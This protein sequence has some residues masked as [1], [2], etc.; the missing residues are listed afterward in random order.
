MLKR[1]ILSFIFFSKSLNYLGLSFKLTYLNFFSL[2]TYRWCSCMQFETCSFCSKLPTISF[3]ASYPFKFLSS[4]IFWTSHCDIHL[5]SLSWIFASCHF[6]YWVLYVHLQ[7]PEWVL[8]CSWSNPILIFFIDFS[9]VVYRRLL[10]PSS[11]VVYSLF[12]LKHVADKNFHHFS[13]ARGLQSSQSSFWPI[14]L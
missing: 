10:D 2:A 7:S 1:S 13:L 6:F 8:L 3:L 5:S 12:H 9:F 4:L 14:I 11:S